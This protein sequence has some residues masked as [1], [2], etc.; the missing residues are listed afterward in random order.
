MFARALGPGCRHARYR[1]PPQHAV[2]GTSL[3]G[4]AGGIGV[5][6]V[7][8][9]WQYRSAGCTGVLAVQECWLYR[10]AGCTGVLIHYSPTRSTLN[11]PYSSPHTHARLGVTKNH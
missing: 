8:E 2:V 9:C 10:S 3:Q 1:A 7:Q 5:L 11:V 6:A 4:P